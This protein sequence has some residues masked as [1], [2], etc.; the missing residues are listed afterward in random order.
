M[1]LISHRGNLNGIQKKNEN[2]P[3]YIDNAL[4]EGYEVEVDVRYENGDF[5]LG[6]DCNQFKINEK[7]LLR[8]GIWCHAKTSFALD[9]LYKIKAHHFWH[10]EDDYTITSRGYIWSYPGKKLLDKSICVLP[11]KAHYEKINCIGICSDTIKK[12]KK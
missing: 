1:I 5:F 12:Y 9:A 10:Q 8:K 7:Y 4:N 2:N 6:H 3:N 11:E